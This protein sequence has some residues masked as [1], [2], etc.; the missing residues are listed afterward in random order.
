MLLILFSVS[1]LL[2]SGIS[3]KRAASAAKADVVLEIKGKNIKKA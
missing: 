1:T 3:I 2:F